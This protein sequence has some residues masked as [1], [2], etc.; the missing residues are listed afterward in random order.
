M[1]LPNRCIS[2]RWR[3]DLTG[4]AIAIRQSRSV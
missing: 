3:S 4:S 1:S 2:E